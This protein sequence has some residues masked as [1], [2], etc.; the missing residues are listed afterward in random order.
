M[1]FANTKKIAQKT[2][3]SLRDVLKK[4]NQRFL[5]R[6]IFFIFKKLPVTSAFVLL[7]EGEIERPL[8][9]L[10]YRTLGIPYLKNTKN[11]LADMHAYLFKT[12]NL[13]AYGIKRDTKNYNGAVL[14]ALHSCGAF[15]AS[16]YASRSVYLLQALKKQGVDLHALVRPGYP[17]DLPNHTNDEKCEY[18][19]YDG[20][21]FR[22][23][24]SS[25]VS[26]VSPDSKYIEGYAQQI[27]HFAKGKDISVLHA[28]SNY[29][30]GLAV[31]KAGIIL[32]IKSIYELR[33]LWHITRSFSN[34]K[35]ANSEHY[36]Y[37]EK[38]EIEACQAVD[39][40]I[41]LSDAMKCWLVDRGVPDEKIHIIGNAATPPQSTD[42][43]KSKATIRRQYQIPQDAVV[44]GYVGSLLP[45]EGLDELLKLHGRTNKN[46]RPYILIVGD[47]KSEY[48]LRQ[49]VASLD[50]E[51]KVIF[52]GRVKSSEVSKYYFA[53]DYVALPRKDHE[54]TNLV[55]A[56][57]PFE[58]LAHGRS[59]L[60]SQ[61]LA[62]ALGSTL[63]DQSYEIC[64]FEEMS[65]L[66]E[67]MK[68]KTDPLGI[69][70]VPTWSS[71]ARKLISIYQQR[72]P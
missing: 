36:R 34:P 56:I 28:A 11:R 46:I 5:G 8:S 61:P 17:W 20:I 29:H 21:R 70:E 39:L 23:F 44:I 47:G 10:R 68:G 12:L 32:G 65:S 45:Y 49:I 30:N 72:R 13:E 9:L 33:G 40:V 69:F 64:D 16:G 19:E 3:L 51:D 4:N 14:Y 31:A 38:R 24:P 25:P 59:L 41:T 27:I 57:K 58:V 54:I 50:T 37:V 63:P 52:A 71:R 60:L 7:N 43:A 6:F 22:F 55:P 35:Y 67:I 18:L 42:A 1:V 53:M 15:D 66:S 48:E 62:N 2:K 26:L